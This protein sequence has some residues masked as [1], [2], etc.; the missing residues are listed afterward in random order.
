MLLF[1]TIYLFCDLNYYLVKYFYFLIKA[2][3]RKFR[4]EMSN[5]YA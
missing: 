4:T 5:S 3:L 2:A 1:N